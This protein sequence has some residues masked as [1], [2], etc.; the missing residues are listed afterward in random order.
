MS[1]RCPVPECTDPACTYGAEPAPGDAALHDERRGPPAPVVP[2]LG[3]ARREI[4]CHDCGQAVSVGVG[5]PYHDC[6]NEAYK[7]LAGSPV[8]QARHDLNLLDLLR[9]HAPLGCR[10][11][12]ERAIGR[13]RADCE[14]AKAEARAKRAPDGPGDAPEPDLARIQ[15]LID[16]EAAKR[17]AVPEAFGLTRAQV[18]TLRA[19]D[20]A[21]RALAGAWR[22][23]GQRTGEERFGRRMTEIAKLAQGIHD[24]ITDAVGYAALQRHRDPLTAAVESADRPEGAAARPTYPGGEG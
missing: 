6:P 5:A 23:E 19:A 9:D 7:R 17:R 1:H 24:A 15:G 3:K 10:G 14:A 4:A 22:A 2:A 11:A 13:L 18:A 20:E 12:L 21:L 16:S 8:V